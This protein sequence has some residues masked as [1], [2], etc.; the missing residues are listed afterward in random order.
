MIK[1]ISFRSSL[2]LTC[3]TL[4]FELEIMDSIL[5]KRKNTIDIIIPVVHI[6]L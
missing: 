5:D 2:S 3:T 6:S 1:R 4:K